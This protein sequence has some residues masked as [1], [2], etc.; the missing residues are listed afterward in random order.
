MRQ[1]LSCE[2]LLVH[3]DRECLFGWLVD[4]SHLSKA[5]PLSPVPKAGLAQPGWNRVL[6][7]SC[8]GLAQQCCFPTGQPHAC[9]GTRAMWSFPV[10]LGDVLC[11][12][13][14]Q[15]TTHSGSVVFTGHVNG[16]FTVCEL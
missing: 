13:C 14:V 6:G 3:L 15:C 11:S 16:R 8:Q 1:S 9:P 7:F 5:L 2:V 4:V 10:L 12:P